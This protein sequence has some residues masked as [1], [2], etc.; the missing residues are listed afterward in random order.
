MFLITIDRLVA[1]IYN[2]RYSNISTAFRAKVAI[3]CTWCIPFLIITL[4]L[5]IIS[6]QG[7]IEAYVTFDWYIS[8]TL[9]GV[10]FLFTVC[11]Y[12]TM[13]VI[14]IRSHT[15]SSSHRHSIWYTFVQSKFYVAVLLISS[16]LVLVAVPRITVSVMWMIHTFQTY[17]EWNTFIAMNRILIYSFFI[18]DTVD[19]FIYILLYNPVRSLLKSKVRAVLV[20][21]NRVGHRQSQTS[22]PTVIR[23][24]DQ[25]KFAVVMM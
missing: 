2:I 21:L 10:H 3:M 25:R 11:S 8:P 1:C 17:Q 12:I 18:S 13:F 14:F 19:G 4:A 15:R 7:A 5:I 6:K 9:Y 22:E 24:N 16:F 20:A 23:N